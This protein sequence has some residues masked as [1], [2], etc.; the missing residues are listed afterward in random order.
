MEALEE[1]RIK[2]TNSD[3]FALVRRT[4]A[5]GMQHHHDGDVCGWEGQLISIISVAYH[6]LYP[7]SLCMPS[8]SLSK[9]P[10]LIFGQLEVIRMELRAGALAKYLAHGDV[11]QSWLNYTDAAMNCS[12]KVFS[13]VVSLSKAG[14]FSIS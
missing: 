14:P 2:A 9:I 7:A 8:R 3:L 12:E 10:R 5:D 13:S 4:F 1:T 11:F 6:V